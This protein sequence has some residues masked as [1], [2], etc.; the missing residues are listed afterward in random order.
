MR[1]VPDADD[2]FTRP[3]GVDV[4]GIDDLELLP[5]RTVDEFNALSFRE[6]DP[7]PRSRCNSSEIACS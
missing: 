7:R 5:D 2:L 6:P 3:T 1:P 4:G